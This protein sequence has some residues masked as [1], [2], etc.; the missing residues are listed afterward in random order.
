MDQ[1]EALQ[2]L[3]DADLAI[4]RAKASFDKMP[5][6]EQLA[7]ISRR[8]HEVLI[9]AGQ[10]SDLK[11]ECEDTIHRL[12]DEDNILKKRIAE[13]QERLDGTSD[14]RLIASLTKEMEGAVKRREKVDFQMSELYERLEKIEGAEAKVSAISSRLDAATTKLQG[15]IDAAGEDMRQVIQD[16][17]RQH[18]AAAAE[19]SPELLERYQHL[20]KTKGG[21][22]V[23]RFRDGRCSACNV[24]LHAGELRRIEEGPE[25]GT[26]PRCGR[27]LI[28]EGSSS[29]SAL[30]G[31]V[32]S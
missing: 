19:L 25:I 24:E 13:Q 2:S 9:K 3:Q 7:D 26:C 30:S 17:T 14:H 18:R 32:A 31:E 16:A 1:K 6:K 12:Q 23:A 22:A 20:V 5:E 28:K 10:V 29:V 8:S 11:S 21:I 27:M 4:L 15:I